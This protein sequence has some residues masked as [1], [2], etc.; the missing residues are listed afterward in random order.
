MSPK[1]YNI[2]ACHLCPLRKGGNC[3]VA[4]ERIE[5]QISLNECPFP[6]GTRFVKDSIHS[7]PVQ[8][9]D[10]IIG[11]MRSIC[12]GC[13][14]LIGFP[15]VRRVECRLLL[16]SKSKC[17]CVRFKTGQCPAGFWDKVLFTAVPPHTHNS[18]S[19]S[20]PV[21]PPTQPQID[22]SRSNDAATG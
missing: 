3:T 18:A 22:T 19:Q 11:E 2:R 20:S 14:N 15:D 4:N 8:R 7:I 16:T 6:A 17:G 13:C 5:H 10:L 12:G 9:T 1:T 21:H